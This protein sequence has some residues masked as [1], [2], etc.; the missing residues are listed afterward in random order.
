L[1]GGLSFGYNNSRFG[2]PFEKLFFAGG[3]YDIRAWRAYNLGPGS[4]PE[5][6]F[7]TIPRARYVATAPI[8]L[9]TNVEYRFPLSRTL[10]FFKDIK[11]AV[12][13]D[14]GNIW[15]NRAAAGQFQEGDLF[16]PYLNDFLFDVN[17]FYKQLAVGGGI[18][19]RYDLTF[20]VLRL[21]TAYKLRDP[22]KPAGETWLAHPLNFGSLTYNIAI[23][24]PF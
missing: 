11:G 18:G 19:F 4:V 14:I 5:S 9:M 17:R 12:F 8:K 7:E 22:A 13:T 15:W 2:A 3:S 23:G 21:D 16:E 6:I 24:Y 1:L 10:P 20:F